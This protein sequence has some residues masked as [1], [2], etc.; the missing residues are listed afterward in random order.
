MA[1][2]IGSVTEGNANAEEI[3][4]NSPDS[5]LY[6][7]NK[8]YLQGSLVKFND[9]IYLAKRNVPSDV[10]LDNPYYWEIF[11]DAADSKRVD[12]LFEKTGNLDEL[13]TESKDNLVNAINEAVLYTAQS[14][15]EEQQAQAR[16]NIGADISTKM[17]ANNPVGTGS[18]SMNR[19]AGTVVG[20]NSHAEGNDTTASGYMSHAEGF[21]TTASGYYSHAEGIDT[22]ASGVTTHAEGSRTRTSGESSHAEGG[23]TEANGDYSHAE[24]YNTKASGNYSHVQGKYNIEDTSN[25]YSDIIGNG[26]STKRSNAATVDWNGNAW[27]AGDVYTGSTSGTNKDEGSKKLATEEYVDSSIAANSV[28]YTAQSLTEE[29]KVQARANIGAGTPYTL[30]QA[31]AEAIGGVKAD[32]AEAADTQPVRIGGDGKLYTTPGG[33]DISLGLTSAAV[34]QTIKVKA[35]D[36]SGK[37]TAWEAA[38]MPSG[39]GSNGG[40]HL[41]ARVVTEANAASIE[42]TGLSTTAEVLSLRIYNPGSTCGEGLCITVNGIRK[43]GYGG[44]ISGTNTIQAFVRAWLYRDGGTLYGRSQM[45]NEGANVYEWPEMG[46]ITS[47]TVDSTYNDGTTKYF[48]AGTI[49]EIYEGMY[50]NVQ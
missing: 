36:E 15:T 16:A 38:N 34:G 13:E 48:Q 29:Q 49:F 7:K 24:G 33:T 9:K 45:A 22:T 18:F 8:K 1:V 50:P 30:L 28:L 41:I 3:K 5:E 37:P 19:K 26:T 46:E 23:G 17:D 12:E 21:N 42:V 10:D 35:V 44:T 39:S 31:T 11:M 40:I 47:I 2:T 6:E 20:V 14:L 27:F 32:S 43:L 25:T 4:N